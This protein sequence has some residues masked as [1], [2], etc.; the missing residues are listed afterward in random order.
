MENQQTINLFTKISKALRV[1]QKF[2]ISQDMANQEFRTRLDDLE[3]S[4]ES[5]L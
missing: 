2:Q 1:I 4:I 5:D 3:M